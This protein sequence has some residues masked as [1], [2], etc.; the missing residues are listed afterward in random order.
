VAITSNII[1]SNTKTDNMPFLKTEFEGLLIYD[2]VV[3]EDER[4]FF[5]ESYNK[6]NFFI[7]GLDMEFVQDNQSL[8]QYGVVRGLHFQHGNNAQAK[9]VSVLKGSV[10]DVVVDIRTGSPTYGKVFSIELNET[11]KKQLFVPKGF[12]H[13]YAVLSQSALFFY[14][15][16]NYYHK[17][18]EGGINLKDNS[19][20]IDWQVPADQM[21]I[22]EKDRLLPDF[23]DALN[24][25]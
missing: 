25:F 24:Y 18:A 12:A 13:G 11:S 19:L 17:D 20:A 1:R 9:L 10:L 23:K 8:S 6:R 21:I 4:G 22:S 2:P 3:Y 16:N 15:C 14:K 5:Y 7:E